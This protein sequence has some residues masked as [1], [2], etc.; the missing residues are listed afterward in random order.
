MA[1]GERAAPAKRQKL[2]IDTNILLDVVLERKP[3]VEDATALLDA[4][5]RGRAEGYVAS[6]TIPTVYYVVARERDRTAATTA[7]TDL[8]Q[9]LTVVPLDDAGFQRALT[10]SV[11]DFEDAAQAAACLEV[12][13]DCLVT[14]NPADYRGAPVTLRSAGEALALLPPVTRGSLR[15]E[16]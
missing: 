7:T 5:A 11:K 8:L 10:L 3:W 9:L 4:I 13:A 12:G 2:L 15:P 16:T 1:V 14:R 6:H